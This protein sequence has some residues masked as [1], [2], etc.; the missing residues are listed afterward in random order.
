MRKVSK[1]ELIKRLDEARAQVEIGARYRHSKSDGQYTVLDIVLY[2][3]TEQPVV[4]YRSEYGV[5]L[6]WARDA[7]VFVEP[8]EIDGQTTPRFVKL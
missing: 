7:A 3:P 6:V 8:V 1:D 2:E 5:K 4:I